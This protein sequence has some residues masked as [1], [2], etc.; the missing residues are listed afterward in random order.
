MCLHSGRAGLCLLNEH[1]FVRCGMVCPVWHGRVAREWRLRPAA[2]TRSL[3]N[4]RQRVRQAGSVGGFCLAVKCPVRRQ[5]LMAISRATFIA[6]HLA[7]ALANGILGVGSVI[8]K[9]GLAGCNPIAVSYTHLTLP[10]KA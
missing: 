9:I 6:A 5:F 8:T 7:L 4:C 1:F 10:T 3:G 2:G